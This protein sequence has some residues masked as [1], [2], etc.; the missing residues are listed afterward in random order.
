MSKFRD[1]FFGEQKYITVT[2]SPSYVVSTTSSYY[3]GKVF[4]NKKWGYKN[5]YIY[6]S[7][8]GGTSLYPYFDVEPYTLKDVQCT[9]KTLYMPNTYTSG[10]QYSLDIP[11][12]FTDIT[13]G[14]QLFLQLTLESAGLGIRHQQQWF[15]SAASYGSWIFYPSH[16][17][18]HGVTHNLSLN[19]ITDIS[20][21]KISDSLLQL[22]VNRYGNG[23]P[24]TEH[25]CTMI[26]VHAIKVFNS[27]TIS[28]LNNNIDEMYKY[29]LFIPYKSYVPFT[30]Y[31]TLNTK[32]LDFLKLSLP[33]SITANSST[34]IDMMTTHNLTSCPIY[35]TSSRS[36]EAQD[37]IEFKGYLYKFWKGAYI[38]I[39]K[40]NPANYTTYLN[41]PEA[42]G[43][44]NSY[45]KWVFKDANYLYYMS[46]KHKQG[47]S[48][49][50]QDT[51]L[52][53]SADG[54]NWTSFGKIGA[55]GDGIKNVIP[56]HSP[57]SLGQTKTLIYSSRSY[58]AAG[59]ETPHKKLYLLSSS[60]N[61][62]K[63][64][65]QTLTTPS[66]ATANSY[67]YI[68]QLLGQTYYYSYGQGLYRYNG[69]P[70]NASSWVKPTSTPF[71]IS[72]SGLDDIIL[73]E[74]ETS[75]NL[76]AT[77][78]KAI[79][80]KTSSVRD[81]SSSSS[82]YIQ[83]YY[84]TSDGI[85]FTEHKEDINKKVRGSTLTSSSSSAISYYSDSYGTNGFIRTKS[86]KKFWYNRY[87]LM[88][89]TDF[90]TLFSLAES[91]RLSE[92]CLGLEYT[93]YRE[94]AYSEAGST[95]MIQLLNSNGTTTWTLSI[96]TYTNKLPGNVP[97]SLYKNLNTDNDW[98]ID[99]SDYY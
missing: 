53:Y 45:T 67:N 33:S 2:N 58:P 56:S 63:P 37:L 41:K 97:G 95:N 85:N 55:T 43:S 61:T 19:V 7:T 40:D 98:Y 8:S 4:D 70:T 47:F 9:Q 90:N 66:E 39:Q 44:Y 51:L 29:K 26:T 27:P 38:R 42:T 80:F 94:N 16:P 74:K 1:L 24:C 73:T 76:F 93:Y 22:K 81:T 18:H 10:E 59:S 75:G 91:S 20:I 36:N 84:T 86:N 72:T 49:E 12:T 50:Y 69:E 28:Y 77:G 60:N 46:V 71:T 17:E 99:A 79:I 23:V 68:F 65:L 15:A 87:M 35:G 89:V 88:D 62:T 21:K 64:V 14:S 13:D 34:S 31:K 25:P 54:I 83:Q 52:Y 96:K 3:N 30:P 57:T 82:S 78:K 32:K 92:A 6:G 11:G 5:Y 48:Y